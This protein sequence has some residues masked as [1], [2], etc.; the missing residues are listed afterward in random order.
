MVRQL[1]VFLC[2]LLI[3]IIATFSGVAVA[4]GEGH[5][6]LTH[7]HASA[8]MNN[9]LE[10]KSDKA[11]FSAVVFLLLFALLYGLAWKPIS[12]GL[13]K[14]EAAI[15]SQITEAKQA[16]ETAAIKLKEYEAKLAEAAVQ[17][18]EMV[19]QARKDAEQV[20]ERIRAEAQ[21]E[22]T[23]SR[24]RALAEI[25]SAKQAALSDL[26]TKS[27]DMAFALARRFVGRELKAEDHQKLI[28]EAITN[29]PS[30]N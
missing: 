3:A 30:K 12:Q 29:L 5:E 2:G 25:E 20:G 7:G 6:D 19:T 11:L 4:S 14:R 21:A 13:S 27:T 10:L 15:A 24:D 1:P 16:A 23:R 18:Q 22:A 9:L 8:D 17:A 28:A 26:T